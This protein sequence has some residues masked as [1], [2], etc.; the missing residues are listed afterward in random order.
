MKNKTKYKLLLFFLILFFLSTSYY[1]GYTNEYDLPRT[2]LMFAP[3]G[4]TPMY[5]TSIINLVCFIS[6]IVI[7]FSLKRGDKDGD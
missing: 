7:L 2:G 4:Y 3:F 1:I 6:L 5:I